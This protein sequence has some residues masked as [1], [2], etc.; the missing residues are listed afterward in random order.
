MNF[1]TCV[2]DL[3]WLLLTR[4]FVRLCFWCKLIFLNFIFYLVFFYPTWNISPSSDIFVEGVPHI[5]H[6]NNMGWKKSPSVCNAVL[7]F[8]IF[9][10]S[11]T[12]GLIVKE[13][14]LFTW[15]LVLDCGLVEIRNISDTKKPWML[16]SLL[17]YPTETPRLVEVCQYWTGDWCKTY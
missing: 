17:I 1:Y 8:S 9:L 4:V 15:W 3:H 11:Y 16:K 2:H 6:M 13:I 5:I 14:L 7:V 12:A 10:S